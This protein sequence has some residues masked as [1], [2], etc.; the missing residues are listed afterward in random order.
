MPGFITRIKPV[1]PEGRK[2]SITIEGFPPITLPRSEAEGLREGQILTD[3][4]VRELLEK[5]D[6]SRAWEASLRLL[7]FRPRSEQEIRAR[8]SRKFPPSIVEKTIASLRERGF[9]DDRL[10]ARYWVE[11]R[12]E[13]KPS[14]FRKLR[15][16]L[17]AKGVSPEIIREVL[18]GMDFEEEACKAA[19]RKAQRWRALDELSFK[20]KAADFLARQGFSFDIIERVLPRVWREIQQEEERWG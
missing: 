1:G 20:K 7:R 14:G 3:D 6:L 15:H 10:F 16:E 8:L 12:R 5:A 2:I 9:I 4:Q 17:R 19:L 13:F 11:N 18:E